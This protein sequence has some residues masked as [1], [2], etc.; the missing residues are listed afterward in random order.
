MD[1]AGCELEEVLQ[2]CSDS[3]SPGN[4]DGHDGGDQPAAV[5][6][7]VVPSHRPDLRGPALALHTAPATG[8]HPLY[9]HKHRFISPPS[10][11]S[12]VR[13][14]IAPGFRRIP[15]KDLSGHSLSRTSRED[16]VKMSFG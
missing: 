7:D 12:G 3:G 15:G 10:P 8:I 11:T 6:G 9:R 13:G 4:P 16:S 1:G 5:G 2:P 14:K